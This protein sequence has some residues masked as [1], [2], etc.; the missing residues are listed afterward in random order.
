M[1]DQTSIHAERRYIGKA[2]PKGLVIKALERGE[3]V[4]AYFIAVRAQAFAGPLKRL[5]T[6]EEVTDQDEVETVMFFARR[7]FNTLA[8]G[9]LSQWD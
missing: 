6:F 7:S 8:S 4:A 2:T 1:T 9:D 5:G 3:T